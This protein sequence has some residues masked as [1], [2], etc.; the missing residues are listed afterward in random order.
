MT[1][2]NHMYRP[3]SRQRAVLRGHWK[4]GLTKLGHAVR[5]LLY[6]FTYLLK[7]YRAMR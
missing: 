5:K 1:E 6:S 3:Q 7:R 2:H 4:G